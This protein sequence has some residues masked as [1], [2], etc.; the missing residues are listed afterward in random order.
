MNI[1]VIKEIKA[2]EYRV[3]LTPNDALA[4][5]NAGHN[6]KVEA[7]AGVGAGFQNTDY[8]AVG[9]Q[10]I[11]NKEMLF[12]WAQMI[13]KVKEP[14]AEEYELFHPDQILFTY[15]HLAADKALTKALLDK[16]VVAIAYETIQKADGS[17]PC[18][19]PMSEIA[20][21]LSIQQGAKYLEKAMGGRGVLLSG[22]PGVQRGK[23]TIIGG[24]VVGFNAAKIAVGLGADVTILDISA[25]RLTYV[26]DIFGSRIQTLYSN[27]SNLEHCLKESD[28]VIGAVLI[29]GAKAPKLVKRELLQSMKA[30]AVIVDVAIDQGGCVET[31][32]P[33]SHCDPIYVIDDV[34][35]YCVAN[36]PGTVSL[37]STL[38]LTSTTLSYGLEIANKGWE[39]ALATNNDLAKGLNTLDGFVTYKPVADSLELP[40]KAWEHHRPDG[41]R[42]TGGSP[43]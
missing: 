27:Q 9:A 26:D 31:S 42:N 8:E 2:H 29:P 23:V 35:H 4:Y 39:K 6:V 32:K 5:I 10:I 41:N 20:G 24:G 14:L 30:G 22:V 15:L 3:G 13:V 25:Q 34:V 37:T 38:A 28:L 43:V 19:T 36:M 7:N 33:T 21:R 1:A 16:K 17:L 40:F 18:L 12:N 11:G